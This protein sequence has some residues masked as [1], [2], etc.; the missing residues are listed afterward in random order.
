MPEIK[1]P[2]HPAAYAPLTEPPSRDV[3]TSDAERKGQR[4]K[5]AL[6]A[7]HA[8]FED[9]GAELRDVVVDLL[10]DLMHLADHNDRVDLERELRQAEHNYY[11]ERNG[12]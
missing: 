10:T 6:D 4:A 9:D 5:I 2:I 11:C 1:G 3:D 12:E 8:V 7:Y